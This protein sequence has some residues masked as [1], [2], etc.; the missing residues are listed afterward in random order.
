MAI[1]TKSER[2][3]RIVFIGV[4]TVAVGLWLGHDALQSMATGNPIAVA[5][6]R[7]LDIEW[8]MWLGVAGLTVFF[9]VCAIGAGSG[10][11]RPQ[12][13]EWPRK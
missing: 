13:G 5:T 8:W 1:M 12:G 11:I 2:N 9:E 6:D 3:L 7:S 10:I 4:A